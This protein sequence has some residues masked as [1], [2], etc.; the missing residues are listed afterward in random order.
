MQCFDLGYNDIMPCL[1]QTQITARRLWNA[2]H[3][4]DYIQNPLIRWFALF[5]CHCIYIFN[6][7]SPNLFRSLLTFSRSHISNPYSSHN[8]F[9]CSRYPN[10]TNRI[11]FPTTRV[12]LIRLTLSSSLYTCSI[13]TF[14]IGTNGHYSDHP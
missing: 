4:R 12:F 6:L 10:R 11:T 3:V 1:L 5:G 13:S 2:P 8:C 7:T 14:T 9:T